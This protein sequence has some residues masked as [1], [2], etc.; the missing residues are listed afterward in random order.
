VALNDLLSAYTGMF[1]YD[2]FY[3]YSTDQYC[4]A[5]LLFLRDVWSLQQCKAW[6][7]MVLHKIHTIDMFIQVSLIEHARRIYEAA[8]T[9][10]AITYV[11]AAKDFLD[12]YILKPAKYVWEKTP[13][14]TKIQAL[15]RGYTVRK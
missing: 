5:T 11:E 9:A 8:D 15:W 13:H 2:E 14:A 12:D 4:D 7:D 3:P 6:A 1:P 10:S